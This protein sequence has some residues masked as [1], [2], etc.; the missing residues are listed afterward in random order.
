MRVL[1]WVGVLAALLGISAPAQNVLIA[2]GRNRDFSKSLAPY[3][4]SPQHVVDLMLDLAD[5][6]P[7]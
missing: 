3:V 1:I 2:Q 7:G 5:L 6:R 4:V